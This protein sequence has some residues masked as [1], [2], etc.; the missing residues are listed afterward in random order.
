[1][2]YSR[3]SDLAM[4]PRDIWRCACD[5]YVVFAVR[6]RYM[7]EGLDRRGDCGVW[8]RCVA[9]GR[10]GSAVFRKPPAEYKLSLWSRLSRLVHVLV[11]VTPQCRNTS[12]ATFLAS[13]MNRY[14]KR[15]AFKS[16]HGGAR[17]KSAIAVV[18]IGIRDAGCGRT[19]L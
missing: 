1:M 8:R 18:G 4:A 16:A 13:V 7:H 19:V 11:H 10:Q 5:T 12:L 9:C 2:C 3:D 17:V 14:S 15:N 6:G